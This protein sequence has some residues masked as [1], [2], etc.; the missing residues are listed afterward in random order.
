MWKQSYLK[1]ER[2]GQDLENINLTT[3]FS[4]KDGRIEGLGLEKL[5]RKKTQWSK[6]ERKELQAVGVVQEYQ[7]DT[8]K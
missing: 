4:K 1:Q 2:D 5:M 6:N 3:V 7:K 8:I